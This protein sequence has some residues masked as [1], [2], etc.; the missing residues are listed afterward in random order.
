M[1]WDPNYVPP[2]KMVLHIAQGI[3]IFVLWCLE[4]AVFNADKAKI[5]GNNGW[6]FGVVSS[7]R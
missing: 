6:T 2:V 5:V 4:L 1:E 7:R 3:L